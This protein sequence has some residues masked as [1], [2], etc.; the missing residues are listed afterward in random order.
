MMYRR[1]VSLAFLL[2]VIALIAGACNLGTAPEAT[3]TLTA[4][5]TEAATPTSTLTLLTLMPPTGA[6]PPT[7]VLPPTVI[8]QVP[9]SLPTQPPIPMPIRIAILSPVPGSIVSGAVNVI[10]SAVHPLFAQYQLEFG[11][12]PNSAELWYPVV[13]VQ[14]FPVQDNSLGVWNTTIIPDGGYQLRLRVFLRDGTSLTTISNGLQVRNTRPTPAPSATPAVARPT[15]AFAQS[16]TLGE[17]P[18]TVQFTNYSSGVI[19]SYQ[20][21]FGDGTSSSEVNPVKTFNRPGLFNVTLTVSGPG[22]SSSVSSQVLVNAP[23]APRAAFTVTPNSGTVPLTVQFTNQSSGQISSYFWNFGDGTTSTEASPRKT[24]ASVGTF[25]V[26]LTVTGPGGVGI[27]S[28]Q[29]QV[30]NAQTPPPQA[31]FA[32]SPMTGVAPLAVQFSDRSTG[33]VTAYTWNF[34][35]G[36]IST[37]QNPQHTYLAGGN[38]VVTLIVGGPGGQSSLAQS[39]T[40][41]V[42]SPTATTPATVIP[43]ATLTNT[44]LPPSA[45]LTPTQL[46]P[47]LTPT[48]TPTLGV[49]NTPSEVLVLPSSTFTPLP[50]SETAVPPTVTSSVTPVPPSETFTP[51]PPSE[52]FTPVP[53]TSTLTSTPLPPPQVA[54][55]WMVPDPAGNPLAVSF[56]N[57]SAVS[58]TPLLLWNFGDGLTSGELNPLHAYAAGGT[59]TVTLTVTDAGGTSSAQQTVTVVQNVSAAFTFAPLPDQPLT[60]QFTDASTGP[61]VS[62]TWDFSGVGSSNQQ[63]PLFTFPAGGT[64]NVTLT[65]NGQGGSS[66][67]VTFTVNVTAPPTPIPTVTVVPL[68]ADFTAAA[69]QGD[70]TTVDFVGTASDP[71]AGYSWGFGDGTV[72]MLAG[73]AVS[74]TYAPGTYL[75]TMTATSADGLQTFPVQKQVTVAAP[76]SADFSAVPRTDDPTMVDFSATSNDPLASFNWAFGD[77]LTAVGSVVT[78]TYA[79]GSYTVTLTAVSADGLQT[80]TVQKLVTVTAPLS[81]DFSAAPRTDDPTTV[82]FSATSNDPGA[83]FAWSF[84]DGSTDAGA[85]VSHTFVPGTYDVVLTTTSADSSQQTTSAQSVTVESPTIEPTIEPTAGS[86]PA[87]TLSA[88]SSQIGAAFSPGGYRL[89]TAGMDGGVTIWDVVGRMAALT[90]SGQHSGSV[91]SVSWSP[92]GDQLASGGDDGLIVVWETAGGGSQH[93]FS[94]G[95]AVTSIAWSPDGARIAAGLGS[96]TVQIWDVSSGTSTDVATSAYVYAVAWRPDGGQL[97]IAAQD[98][99]VSIYDVGAGGMAQTLS[100]GGAAQALA[101][102]PGGDRLAVGTADSTATIFETAGWSSVAVLIGHSQGVTAI[103]Y[104]PNGGVVIATGSDDGDVRLWSSFDGTPQGSPLPTGL[105]LTALAYSA[106]AAF[107]ATTSGTSEVLVWQP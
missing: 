6:P 37:E 91:V 104:A 101:W 48:E 60:V 64:Y 32:F 57:M 87:F 10:G 17:L 92:S 77:G 40:V 36:S 63:N 52:T 2:I 47:S 29:V 82:D 90:L 45:T 78:N 89:A 14:Y 34:G 3:A 9:T 68:T 43:S 7:S 72:A 42:P 79:P 56:T 62:W 88:A 35:D 11:P 27:T 19:S 100:V 53:P 26:F 58:G 38:Y 54:F 5:N 23:S 83:T 103:A 25:N 33:Q 69:R 93:V 41:I 94:T 61:V 107:L 97:A 8:I 46:L 15:A 18:L 44:P 22:G 30:R 71:L 84:G 50:P 28:Q 96:G 4:T 66:S 74:H 105:P 24:Y 51:V 75:V 21:T 12:D 31:A 99:S 76:L 98:G 85:V 59:Y 81:A 49:T 102:S 86:G 70:P 65:V 20:W 16:A 55:S 73:A 80:A 95:A 1:P 67:S 39:I 13:P 106:D